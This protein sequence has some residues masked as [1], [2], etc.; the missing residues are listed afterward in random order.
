MSSRRWPQQPAVLPSLAC[1]ARICTHA[2]RLRLRRRRHCVIRLARCQ[3]PPPRLPRTDRAQLLT[4]RVRLGSGPQKG[5]RGRDG[6]S[7]PWSRTAA[8]LCGPVIRASVGRSTPRTPRVSAC[9]LHCRCGRACA[10]VVGRTFTAGWIR[11]ARAVRRRRL[12]EA[13]SAG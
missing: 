1:A 7:V 4:G 11:R 3:R 12:M 10:R 8:G 9:F 13:K 2:R 5:S 6:A